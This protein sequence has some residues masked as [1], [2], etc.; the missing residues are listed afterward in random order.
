M[1]RTATILLVFVLLIAVGLGVFFLYL[2]G[3]QSIPGNAA[4]GPT[5]EGLIH[6]RSIYVAGEENMRRPVGVG[7]GDDGFFVTMRDT[8]RIAEFDSNGDFVRVW[9]ERGTDP[10]QLMAPLSV[11]V[12]PLAQ[13]V[14]VVDRSRL[15]LIAYDLEGEYLWEIPMLS[16]LG[17][18]LHPDGILVTS[19][20]PL[21]VLDPEGQL[22]SESGTRGSATG[23]YD[24]PRAA[25]G[26]GSGEAIV[27][28]TNNSRVQRVQMSGEVTSSV[29]WVVGEPPRYQDDPETSFGVP[30]GITQ[31]D[32]GRIYVL[33][34]FR[35]NITVMDP[36][37]GETLHTFAELAGQSDGFFNLPT[38][39]AY[40]GGDRFAVTD[41]YNDRVQ[42]IRLLL[43]GENT[44]IARNP[45]IQW[46]ALLPL[47]LLLL[48]FGRKRTFATEELLQRAVDGGNARLFLAVFKR[49]HV[50]PA[51]Y[52]RFAG[53]TEDGVRIGDYLE[54]TG[55]AEA[56]G[57]T[58]LVDVAR[59]AGIRRLLFSRHTVLCV[60]AAQAARV[61]DL[62]VKRAVAYDEV[63]ADYRIKGADEAEEPP[64]GIEK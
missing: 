7:A 57:E 36:D 35:H 46:L 41:T 9:G 38:S 51:V 2:T 17:V 49:I 5:E 59:P 3:G 21:T 14:Y 31:D 43:P 6:V 44:V 20:G 50:L 22:I 63:V 19:F 23:Q 8:Q 54:P 24:Y 13:H 60:D 30:S 18:A 29:V 64:S 53:L 39:I 4:D 61:M 16:P 10:G 26:L 58:A 42:I 52:E 11:A 48:L 47:L 12:D 37:T 56:T 32:R 40:L 28:D 33:D 15:R 1:N 34:G 25:V 62:G 45:W 55:D 27:A